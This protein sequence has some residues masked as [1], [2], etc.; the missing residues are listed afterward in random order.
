[1]DYYIFS[2]AVDIGQIIKSFGSN[3]LLLFENIQKGEVFKNYSAQNVDMHIS[4]QKALHQIIFNEPY[5]R[6]SENVYWYAFIA[7]CEFYSR[8]LPYSQDITLGR[9]TDLIDEFVK[10]DFNID[11]TTVAMLLD[12]HP[13]VNLP[14]ADGI[15]MVGIIP[16][17]KMKSVCRMMNK[18]IIS[19]LK[20]KELLRQSNWQDEEKALIYEAIK[21]VQANINFCNNQNLSLISFCH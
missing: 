2:Y 8:K 18:I 15:P 5:R 13:E 7:L 14:P 17:T 20:I 19:D 1:M 12:G 6:R 4:M 21:G 16:Q 11:L 10:D 3:D 9:E